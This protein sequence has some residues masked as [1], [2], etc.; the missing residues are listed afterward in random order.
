MGGAP[1]STNWVLDSFARDPWAGKSMLE[2]GELVASEL[3]ASRA[4]L[5]L[6]VL[7]WEQYSNALTNDRGFQ[8][9]YLVPVHVP[10]KRKD[11][12]VLDADEGVRSIST[13][14]IAALRPASQGGLHT[15][16]TQTHPADGCA[17]AVVTTTER[18]REL[19]RGEGIV[20]ILGS[21]FARVGKSRMP[22]AP[23]PAA[24]AALDAARDH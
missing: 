14:E 21:G 20:R 9:R 13:D 8:R 19:S 10:R 16:A 6:A 1:R 7:R 5:D 24:Q 4:E 17:G 22:E 18:A 11:P 2:A 12:T 23:V 3:G 15:F